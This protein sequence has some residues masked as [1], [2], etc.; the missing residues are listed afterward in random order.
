MAQKRLTQYHMSSWSQ[1][2]GLPSS[3]VL[4]TLQSPDGYLWIGTTA[5]LIRFDGVRFTVPEQLKNLRGG[6][7]IILSL[8]MDRHGSIWM[9][10]NGGGLL[11]FDGET[12]RE[13][14][15]KEGLPSA[16][17]NAIHVDPRGSLWVG[18]S[19]GLVRFNAGRL[20]RPSVTEPVWSICD[21]SDG[22][23]LVATFGRGVVHIGPGGITSLA[24]L[25]SRDARTVFHSKNGTEW[26]ALP[27]HGLYYSS[28]DGWTEVAPS[29]KALLDVWSLVEDAEGKMWI[30]A[31][32][33][34][35][36]RW[37]GK[38]LEALTEYTGQDNPYVLHL[39]ADREGSLWVG[40]RSGLN[41]LRN[42]KLTVFTTAE[43]LAENVLGPM[44]EVEPGRWLVGTQSAGAAFWDRSGRRST[45]IPALK[46]HRVFAMHR[47]QAGR[48][49][50][51]TDRGI[52]TIENDRIKIKPTYAMLPNSFVFSLADAGEGRQWIGTMSG[53]CLYQSGKCQPFPL[54]EQI[55]K[56]SI[57]AL[58]RDRKNALWLGYGEGA[59]CRYDHKQVRCWGEQ[60]GFDGADVFDLE[61]DKDG[62][63]W[64][65]SMVGLA[66]IQGDTVQ[67]LHQKDGLPFDAVYGITVD[68][69]GRWWLSS[70]EGL[71]QTTVAELRAALAV[72]GRPIYG[73]YFT[74][75]DGMQSATPVAGIQPAGSL[76]VDGKL[77]FPTNRGAVFVNPEKIESN[78]EPPSAVI[79][80]V[81]VDSKIVSW[82]K[83]AAIPPGAR[84]VEI[85]Y[86]GLSLMV[87]E[88]SQFEYQLEGYDNHWIAAGNRRIA[89]YT[90]LPPGQYTFR[91]RATNNDGLWGQVSAPLRLD[92]KPLPWQTMWFRALAFSVALGLVWLWN[93][94]RLR[95]VE[96]RFNAVLA[97]R[98]RIAR[99]LH[100]TL[101]GDFTGFNMQLAA[102][103]MSP[104]AAIS[105]S[106]IENLVTQMEHSLRDARDAIQLLR[107]AEEDYNDFP[108]ML[109]TV[110]QSLADAKA[111]SLRFRV[112]GQMLP[113]SVASRECL[114]RV[115]VEAVRNAVRHSG[116]KCIQV[117]LTYSLDS[118]AAVVSD[119][120][121]GFDANAAVRTTSFGLK[122]MAE[123]ARALEAALLIK[124]SA[125]GTSVDIRV[126]RFR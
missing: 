68:R 54:S 38:R 67:W 104:Q 62:A 24:G 34:G 90:G 27:G 112:E 106:A 41:R 97:E 32:A 70:G 95:V 64:A 21:A 121:S 29:D 75:S 79:E 12:L 88:R 39:L 65:A 66:R 4:S 93:R 73:R 51:G 114:Y 13:F 85:H 108:E 58:H 96:Q 81:V 36:F 61:E 94:R 72:G 53:L 2:Q 9:G 44:L 11:Q 26:V 126:A 31:G 69:S 105:P 33:R 80:E 15:T 20:D 110:C 56:R 45:A 120:G 74:R 116:A 1:E 89:F 109:K 50:L 76:D 23:L 55:P 47:E 52:A 57:F 118:I 123:R 124:S 98:A 22:G 46:N 16:T 111:I 78:R 92:Q 6:A 84:N 59:L 43:G 103:A 18:T 119:D 83:P 5:G 14:N 107:S 87:P 101:L 100:D 102:L 113:I 115:V 35:L 40:S 17:V 37:D 3:T 122:G 99:D 60:D 8:A 25:P 28:A 117:Q 77:W 49:W 10:T 42:D 48:I 125:E 86:T 71:F 30:G 63:I 82:G 19:R 7:A 91:V